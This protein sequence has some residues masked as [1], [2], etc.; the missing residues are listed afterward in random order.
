MCKHIRHGH[1]PITGA[2]A[3]GRLSLAAVGT[4]FSASPG[5]WFNKS[6][7]GGGGTDSS[8]IRQRW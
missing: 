7:W 6:M 1:L 3:T 2:A 5:M 8:P 4:N